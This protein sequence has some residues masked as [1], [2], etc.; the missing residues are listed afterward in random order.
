MIKIA[1]DPNVIAALE[2]QLVSSRLQTSN[3]ALYLTIKGLIDNMTTASRQINATT[4]SLNKQGSTPVTPPLSFVQMYT[5]GTTSLPMTL[6]TSP[7]LVAFR[8]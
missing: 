4:A 5:G 2:T 3:N 1:S 7:F 8:P 6:G